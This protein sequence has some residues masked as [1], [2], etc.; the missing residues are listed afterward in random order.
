MKALPGKKNESKSC[1]QY[2]FH[3]FFS[4]FVPLLIRFKYGKKEF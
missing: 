3:I 2:I 4:T 1:L